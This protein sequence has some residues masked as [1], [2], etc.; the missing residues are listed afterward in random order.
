MRLPLYR[1]EL[2]FSLL[3]G[4]LLTLVPCGRL[5]AQHH[6]ADSSSAHKN[7]TATPASLDFGSVQVGSSASLTETLTNIGKNNL[8]IYGDQ[9]TGNGF[10]LSGI[11]V[12]LTLSPGQS[13]TLTLSFTPLTGGAV[14]GSAAFG[15]YGWRNQLG[16]T[17]TGSGTTPGQLTVSPATADFGNVNLGTSGSLSGTL[18][19]SGAAVTVS[20]VTS[21]NAQFV[22]SGLT[23][24]LTLSAGQSAGYTLTFTPQTAGSATGSLSFANNSPGGSAMQ[25]LTGSGVSPQHS[26][27][28]N[29]SPSTSVVAG[30]NVYRSVVSGGPYAK[31]NG[32]V[33]S[34]PAYTDGSVSAGNIYYYVATS[35]ASDG[36]ESTYSN[37]VQAVVPTP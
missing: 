34:S 10:A 31:I 14:T 22:L 12:P 19:A 3:I 28:L 2:P 7:I 26:V 8:T 5:F 24:P 6:Y 1:A 30:Y 16:V 20:S 23:F 29:W 35:V 9:V 4:L 15:S 25:S 18:A 13:Y 11:T 36:S 33:D 21:S 37:E 27:S 17:L 32:S